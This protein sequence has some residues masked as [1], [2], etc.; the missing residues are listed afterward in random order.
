MNHFFQI[1]LAR[2]HPEHHFF[3]SF[4]YS[5]LVQL[6]SEGDSSA[7]ER[8]DAHVDLSAKAT[9]FVPINRDHHWTLLVCDVKRQQFEYYDSLHRGCGKKLIQVR[10][11]AQRAL[12]S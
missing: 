3:S 12:L 1:R 9:L 7:V 6:A 2:K 11:K 10:K 4:F 8:W 5:K